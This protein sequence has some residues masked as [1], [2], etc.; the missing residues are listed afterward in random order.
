MSNQEQP[1]DAANQENCKIYVNDYERKSFFA[2]R[3]VVFCMW[4]PVAIACVKKIDELAPQNLYVG[5]PVIVFIVLWSVFGEIKYKK[6]LLKNDL[7]ILEF[8]DRFEYERVDKEG[9]INIKTVYKNQITRQSTTILP[10]FDDEFKDSLIR[11]R[12]LK[13]DW[14]N[15][16]FRFIFLYPIATFLGFMFM[17][18][19]FLVY[20]VLVKFKIK[21]YYQCDVDKFCFAIPKNQNQNFK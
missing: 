18:A 21:L 17:V 19:C 14:K 1:N 3:I 6:T 7:K 20:A 16:A 12:M 5:F 11:Y 9:K 8:D 15:D 2:S 10:S 4:L 13:P